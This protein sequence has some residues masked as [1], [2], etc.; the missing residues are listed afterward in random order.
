[1][2]RPASRVPQ[3]RR[4]PQHRH[5]EYRAI[6]TRKRDRFLG[7][8]APGLVALDGVGFPAEVSQVLDAE[9]HR[10]RVGAALRT[11]R[12][13]QPAPMLIGPVGIRRGHRR[14]RYRGACLA[15]MPFVATL[16]LT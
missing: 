10:A 7:V 4:L 1:M 8:A 3:L 9:G 15:S 12:L 5:E 13:R 2:R 6:L 16:L 14:L 11:R